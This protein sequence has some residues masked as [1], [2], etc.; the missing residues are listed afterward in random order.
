M[1]NYQKFKRAIA[2]QILLTAGLFAAGAML[3]GY[4]PAAKGFVLGSLFSLVNFFIMARQAPRL[5]GQSRGR[6]T[7]GSMGSLM[8]RMVVL[9]VPLYIALKTPA[10]SLIWTAVG[11][12]N[13][14]ISIMTQGPIMERL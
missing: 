13:L 4:V 14:Q 5:L 7:A 10:I 9:G 3:L 6:A 8:F 11:I 2:L 1:E 12:F